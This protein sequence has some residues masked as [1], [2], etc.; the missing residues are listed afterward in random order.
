MRRSTKI[1]ATCDLLPHDLTALLSAMRTRRQ[2]GV[3]RQREAGSKGEQA[4]QHTGKTRDSTETAERQH[5][6]TDA[7][8]NEYVTP[9]PDHG[10]QF[11][12]EQLLQ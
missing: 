12:P 6:D 5:A 2:Q 1:A 3:A 9:G 4:V 7:D 10:P 8:G 11:L